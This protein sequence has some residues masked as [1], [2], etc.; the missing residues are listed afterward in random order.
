MS[1]L[2]DR[3]KTERLARF[4]GWHFNTGGAWETPEGADAPV[5][6]RDPLNDAND[7]VA[8]AERFATSN[9]SW[10]GCEM[11]CRVNGV[12]SVKAFTPSGFFEEENQSLP[13]AICLAVLAAL[14]S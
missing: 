1:E 9:Q 12:W 10:N 11:R 4:M 3:E 14:E 8:C 13:R 7:A 6:W 5:C 2:A